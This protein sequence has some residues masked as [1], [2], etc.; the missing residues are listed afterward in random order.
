MIDFILL[1]G[2]KVKTMTMREREWDPT[3]LLIK[4]DDQ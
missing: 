3:A 4:N 2:G 1:S